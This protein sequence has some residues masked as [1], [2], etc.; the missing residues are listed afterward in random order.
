MVIRIFLF[1]FVLMRVL[2]VSSL[3]EEQNFYKIQE[4]NSA[5][6]NIS[7]QVPSTDADKCCK[8]YSDTATSKLMIKLIFFLFSKHLEVYSFLNN[9]F[10]ITE[11]P[12][13]ICDLGCINDCDPLDEKCVYT[14]NCEDVYG[15]VFIAVFLLLF[16]LVC[17]LIF[18]MIAG[19]IYRRDD[20]LEMEIG[21]VQN[22]T[23]P[24][25]SSNSIYSSQNLEKLNVNN[26][27]NLLSIKTANIKK[28]KLESCNSIEDNTIFDE[29]FINN[30]QMT[31]MKNIDIKNLNFPKYL[32]KFDTEKIINKPLYDEIILNHDN[33]FNQALFEKLQN[34]FHYI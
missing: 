24:V 3:S 12:K 20:D 5:S 30:N 32:R 4:D 19:L 10:V 18:L 13:D 26:S 6:V 2:C 34:N 8:C 15:D 7:K 9:I 17:L 21:R 16:F 29:F 1:T 33:N 11:C 22:I 14:K 27:N 28:Y 31:S 23:E 25:I